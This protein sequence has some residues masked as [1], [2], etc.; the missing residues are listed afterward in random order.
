MRHF[1]NMTLALVD[2]AFHGGSIAA[3]KKSMAQA[4][5]AKVIFCTDRDFNIPGID[6]VRIPP[7]RSKKE[8]SKFMVYELWKHFETDFVWVIQHDGYI[9]DIEQW[10][11]EFLNYDGIGASWLYQDG[12]N[13]FNGGFSIRSKKLQTILGTDPAIQVYDP[14]DAIIGRLYRRYLEETHGIKFPPDELCD[15]F[16]YELNEPTFSTV[17]FHGRFW[18]PYQETVVIRREAACGDTIMLEPLLHYFHLKGYRVVLDTLPQFYELFRAHYFPIIPFGQL[19]PKMTYTEYNL[20]MSY[21]ADPKKLHL[22]AYFDFCGIPEKEQIIRNPK[23]N[24]TVDHT[25]TLFPQKYVIFHTDLRE[26]VHRNIY[27]LDWEKAVELLTSKGYLCIHIGKGESKTIPG[28]IRMQ[29]LAEP[30]MAYVIAGCEC[31]IGND[32][33]PSNVALATDRKLIIF[34]GSVNPAYIYPD[35]SK[36]RVITNHDKETPCCP[37]KYCWHESITT[38]GQDCI[39]DKQAPPCSSYKTQDLLDAINEI[40]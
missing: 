8:Y 10:D 5:F 35:M 28:A 9:L 14:E 40:L 37:L 30:M 26:T 17:G 12:R 7:I 21:E 4:T 22:K 31:L 15:R 19:N 23:L 36:V 27:G 33:G 6:I 38:R 24:F 18:P 16:A 20:D 39:V 11:D 13:N 25:N 34:H 2:T 29:T 3:L 1:P 32:S